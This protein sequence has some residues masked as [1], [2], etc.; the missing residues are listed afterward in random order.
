MVESIFLITI[1]SFDR[2]WSI[3]RLNVSISLFRTYQGCPDYEPEWGT[4]RN[5]LMVNLQSGQPK[6]RYWIYA[7][8]SW[9]VSFAVIVPL[10]TRT[11]YDSND[12][13]C[14]VDWSSQKDDSSQPD[15]ADDPIENQIF[16]M[17]EDTSDNKSLTDCSGRTYMYLEKLYI[18]AIGGKFIF[19]NENKDGQNYILV[20]IFIFP[21]ILISVCYV[22]LVAAARVIKT[23]VNKVGRSD[24]NK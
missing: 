22:Q 1:L 5:P 18:F 12:G 24:Q 11:E 17:M 23:E 16:A 6:M 3:T 13:T 8:A 9:L 7:G 10:I 21:L 20:L 14:I 15:T 4:V 2:Y 19:F